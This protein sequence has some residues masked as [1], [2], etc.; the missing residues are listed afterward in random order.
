MIAM[1]CVLSSTDHLLLLELF[2]IVRAKAPPDT[3][4]L[5]VNQIYLLEPGFAWVLVFF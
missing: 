2:T 4:G 5:S 1:C 3:D